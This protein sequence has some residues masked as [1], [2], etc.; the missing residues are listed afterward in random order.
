MY[1]QSVRT[2]PARLQDMAEYQGRV[3]LCFLGVQGCGVDR[4]W[5]PVVFR[6]VSVLGPVCISARDCPIHTFLPVMCS[7]S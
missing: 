5:I 2:V 4:I 6:V 7:D 1:L 3:D